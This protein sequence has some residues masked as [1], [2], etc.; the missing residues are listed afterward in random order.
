MGEPSIV[1]TR[2]SVFVMNLLFEFHI[3]VSDTHECLC[4]RN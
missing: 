4:L 1:T 2:Q 3:S